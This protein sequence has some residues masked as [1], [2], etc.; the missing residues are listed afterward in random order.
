MSTAFYDTTEN[1]VQREEAKRLRGH[2]RA[3]HP[4]L[5]GEG[6]D[7]LIGFTPLPNSGLTRVPFIWLHAIHEAHHAGQWREHDVDYWQ[8][9]R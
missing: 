1:E 2:I 5:L 6:P 3:L 9:E 8:T 7:S 4:N